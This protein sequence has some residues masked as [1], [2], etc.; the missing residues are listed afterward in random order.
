MRVRER[1][2]K[3]FGEKVNKGKNNKIYS[4]V[5]LLSPRACLTCQENSGP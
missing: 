4:R 2:Q 1:G 3:Q 5:A